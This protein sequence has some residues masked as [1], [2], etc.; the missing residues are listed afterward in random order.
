MCSTLCLHIYCINCCSQINM[1]ALSLYICSSVSSLQCYHRV[2]Q[3]Q[4]CAVHRPFLTTYH[5]NCNLCYVFSCSYIFIYQLKFWKYL[6]LHAFLGWHLWPPVDT[7]RGP[8]SLA[9]AP[10]IW[11]HFQSRHRGQDRPRSSDYSFRPS[12]C[13]IYLYSFRV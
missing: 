5:H 1:Q 9:T 6:S 4:S 13:L 3:K 7:S 8:F 11:E 12:L 2:V 10:A